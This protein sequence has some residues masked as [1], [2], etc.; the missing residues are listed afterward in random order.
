[1]GHEPTQNVSDKLW[2][3]FPALALGKVEIRTKEGIHS[4]KKISSKY[5][6]VVKELSVG[7][8]AKIWSQKFKSCWQAKLIFHMSH[9]S[10]L[11]QNMTLLIILEDQ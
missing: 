10:V 4:L 2:L 5:P 6:M 8:R 1:M 7:K 3:Q 11:P 9:L